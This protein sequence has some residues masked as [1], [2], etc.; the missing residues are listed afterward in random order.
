MYRLMIVDDEEIIADGL[1]EVFNNL[2]SLELEV[3]KAYSSEEALSLLHRIRMD[4]VLSDIRMPGMDGL[5]LLSRIRGT[6]P[7][8]KVAFLT[9]Y[10][11]FDYI[12]EAIQYDGVHYMLK[13][14]GYGKII[15]YIEKT[16]AD[17]A[18]ERYE[19]QNIEKAREQ[20]K[21]MSSM[22]QREFLQQLLTGRLEALPDEQLLLELEVPLS[23]EIPLILAI[24][25]VDDPLTGKSYLEKSK[26]LFNINMLADK[27]F[28]NH[29]IKISVID[30][31]SNLIWLIQPGPHPNETVQAEILDST[32]RFVRGTMELI[33]DSCREIFNMSVSFAVDDRPAKWADLADRYSLLKLLIN[34]RIGQGRGMLLT[35]RKITG[36]NDNRPLWTYADA[37][38]IRENGLELL[39]DNLES[40]HG[41][42]FEKTLAMLTGGFGEDDDLL[43]ARAQQSYYSI[44]LVLLSYINRWQLVEKLAFSFNYSRLMRLEEHHS[45]SEAVGFLKELGGHL[46][47]LQESDQE[48]RALDAVSRVQKH[49]LEHLD[50]HDELTLLRLSELVYFNPSYLSRLFKQV[51]GINLSEYIWKVSIKRAK[52]LL[53]DPGLKIR[54]AAKL[55]GYDSAANFARFFKKFTGLTPQEYRDSIVK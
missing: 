35:D 33:Q 28:S 38:Q 26:L 24:G 2:E 32:V 31:G 37:A 47:R 52:E 12:Y 25:R 30:E 34:Y 13:T 3:Y 22:L 41:Q 49:I 21:K 18:R 9:G 36:T 20:L 55:V 42:Q 7:E 1:Y 45:W 51:A 10:N 44:A 29:V 48:K 11:D 39:S 16:V 40:G 54:E 27:Y 50:N 4:M 15:A 43:S 46:I 14:E 17:I 5:Q 53:R 8:C 6:W 19:Q 23:M